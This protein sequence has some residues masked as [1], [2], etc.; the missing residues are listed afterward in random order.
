MKKT[1]LIFLLLF[2][3]LI[4]VAQ[5]KK[6]D[7]LRQALNNANTPDTTRLRLLHSLS[8]YY[9]QSKPDS[10]LIFAQQA[11]GL[12]VKLGRLKDQG[13]ALSHMASSYAGLGDYVKSFSL[14][15]KA[16]KLFETVNNVPNMVLIYNNVGYDYV[17]KQDYLKALPYLKQGLKL[18]NTYIATHVIKRHNE[19]ELHSTLLM[20]VAEVFLYTNKIDSAEYYL[21]ICESDARKNHFKDILNII[22]RDLGEVEIARGHKK[23]ALKRYQDAISISTAND[24]P[25]TLSSTFLSAAKLFHRYKQQDSAEYYAQQA[26]EAAQKEK[27]LQDI[28][29]AG[30]VLCSYY[31]ED[32]NLVQAY[33]YLKITSATKDSLFSQDKVKQLLSL[34]FDEKQRQRDIEDAHVQARNNIRIYVLFAGVLVLLIL[35]FIFWRVSKQRAKANQLLQAQKQE[36]EAAMSKL[37]STQTQL[38]QSEKMA[39]LGELTAGIAHEIQN[40]LN[41]V[42]NFSEVSVELLTELKEEAEAGNNKEVIAIAADLTQNLDKI[43]HHGK[44]ADAIVKGMLKHSQSG[45][46]AKE[47]TNINALADENMRL[48]YHGLR[49]RDKSFNAQLITNFDANLP[50]VNVI[51]QDISRVFLNLFNNAFYTVNQKWKTVGENYKPEVSVSTAIENGWVIIKV[52]DNGIGIPDA[53]KDKIMQPFFTTKPTGEGT[54]LGLSLTYDMVVKGHGGTINVDSQESQGSEF[55]ITLPLS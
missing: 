50:K 54:G 23:A 14:N 18:W 42:N 53:I 38:I 31:E 12:A 6:A 24:D 51:P 48:A 8:L 2:I 22:E 5:S 16:L 47:Q 40:P 45:S 1:A 37:K 15:F 46:G 13:R 33:K 29:N 19:R 3:S 52:K 39:S 11:Y 9:F 43:S 4:A 25:E 7:S 30:K 41:F 32:H 49:A 20:S 44:R 27:F 28:L 21:R 17:Q 26:I 10:C 35:A 36:V 34:D 55:I